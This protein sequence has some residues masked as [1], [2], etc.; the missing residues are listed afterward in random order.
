[1]PLITSKHTTQTHTHTQYT[2][3]LMTHSSANYL[4]RS[5]GEKPV[6]CLTKNKTIGSYGL[7]L[8]KH[9]F[10]SVARWTF[11]QVWLENRFCGKIIL[12]GQNRLRDGNNRNIQFLHR[13]N[14]KANRTNVQTSYLAQKAQSNV[15]VL[16]GRPFAEQIL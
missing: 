6:S 8:C 5:T 11:G 16:V 10:S 3:S 1:M 14:S 15:F 9:A 2:Q 4:L 13:P 7:S 12:S